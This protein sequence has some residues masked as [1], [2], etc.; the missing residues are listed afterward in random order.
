LLR[1]LNHKYSIAYQAIA[2]VVGST[3]SPLVGNKGSHFGTNQT[4]LKKNSIY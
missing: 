2:V 3:A 4:L 1:D